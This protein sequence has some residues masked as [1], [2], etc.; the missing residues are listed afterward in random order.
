MLLVSKNAHLHL[1][2]GDVLEPVGQETEVR[3]Q[4]IQ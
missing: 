3:E 2:P 4:V 1:G